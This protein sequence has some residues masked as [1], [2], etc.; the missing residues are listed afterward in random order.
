[1]KITD[2]TVLALLIMSISLN[3]GLALKVHLLREASRERNRS[4][5]G[6]RWRMFT[7]GIFLARP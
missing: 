7:S 5:W 2:K 6:P 1:M 4:R 3:A